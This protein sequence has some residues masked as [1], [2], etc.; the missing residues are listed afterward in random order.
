[1]LAGICPGLQAVQK[2][3]KQSRIGSRAGEVNSHFLDAELFTSSF[4]KGLESSRK[5]VGLPK[6][7]HN[8]H[9]IHGVLSPQ[10]VLVFAPNS[11]APRL[12]L[13]NW[14]TVFRSACTSTP[15]LPQITATFHADVF[16]E[17]ASRS[18]WLQ[19]W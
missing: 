10:S 6:F 18:Y 5:E 2:F 17:D 14:Q 7:A 3:S 13:Y 12:K 19:S 9:A 16:F 11:P 4:L 15:G 8:K 1:V